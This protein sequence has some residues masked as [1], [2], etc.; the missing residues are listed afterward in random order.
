MV[1][2]FEIKDITNPGGVYDAGDA[3]GRTLEAMSQR[4]KDIVNGR[5]VG[6]LFNI[7]EIDN[8]VVT[9]WPGDVIVICALPGNGKSFVSR[10][11]AMEVLKTLLKHG[12]GSRCVVWV[13]TEESVEKVTAHFISG[14]SG[15]SSTEMLSGKMTHVGKGRIKAAVAEVSTWPLYVIG[16]SL[17][18]RDSDGVKAKTAR[19][20]TSEIDAGLD[21][22]IN[23]QK[24]EISIVIIDYL[25]RIRNEKPAMGREEHIR[26]CVDWSRDVAIWTGAPV[27]L[28]A[29]AQRDVA[30]RTY[31]LPSMDEVEWTAN[32]GQTADAFF[33]L[34]MPKT[35]MGMGI[36]ESFGGWENL[37]IKNSHLFLGVGKQKDGD[38]G[39]IY[40][41]DV[42]PHLMKWELLVPETYNLNDPGHFETGNDGG[43]IEE[44][45][46]EKQSAIPF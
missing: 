9:H 26:T 7:E 29:Q 14:M 46:K 36:I 39:N 8:Y 20:S 25:H 45:E 12:D 38:F 11:M 10:M 16:H 2:P 13:T 23:G 44:K 5:A 24:K 37:Q 40:L 27:I 18:H 15:V 42:K 31:P 30:K 17:S 28:V 4:E 21:Y 19:L 1:D 3:V 43:I 33:G 22:I 6:G 34:W 41:L 35:K 32:A